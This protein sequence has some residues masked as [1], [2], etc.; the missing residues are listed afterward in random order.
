MNKSDTILVL[1]HSGMVGS[2]LVRMLRQ[3]GYSNVA[4]AGRDTADLR[5]ATDVTRVF[6]QIR[7][8][9]AVLAA[10]KVGGILANSRYPADFLYDNLAI[11]CNVIHQAWLSKV[12]TLVMLGSSCIYP[13]E[14]PQPIKEEYLL[15]GPLE[16]TN[17]AYAIAKIA[18]V[19][20][21]QAYERQYGLHCL[22]PMPCNLYGTNDSFDPQNAHVLSS[23]VRKFVDAA[24]AGADSVTIWGTGVA[25][26]EFMHVDDC[27]RAIVFLMENFRSSEVINVGCGSDVTIRELAGMIAAARGL[28]G[29]ARVGPVDAR[30]NAAEVPRR[31]QARGPRLRAVDPAGAGDRDDDR[32]IPVAAKERRPPA[33]RDGYASFIASKYS[34]VRFSPSSSLTF[35]SHP[36]VERARSMSGWRCSGSSSGSGFLT[37]CDL[38]P[39]SA[40]TLSASSA[41]VNSSGLPRFI[42]SGALVGRVPSAPPAPPAGRRRSRTTGSACRRRTG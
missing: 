15:T 38:D 8:D 10:A 5:D 29:Q 13:R 32:R 12:A 17:E 33:A 30:R 24:D 11:E 22:N 41:I 16:P 40:I 4:T 26:R 25:R 34:I 3:S 21:A 28:R 23:L 6:E 20:M 19:K 18:G 14:C 37:I 27:A 1:G 31:Q 35:G 42:G 39:E 7:P 2:A 36:S 9:H